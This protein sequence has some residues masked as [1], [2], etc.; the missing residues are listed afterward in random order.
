MQL[1]H[2][3]SLYDGEYVYSNIQDCYKMINDMYVTS[4]SCFIHPY[5]Q[6]KDKIVN[7]VLCNV[8]FMSHVF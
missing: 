7:K 4:L 3:L 5:M 1:N 8:Y 6:T 2:I